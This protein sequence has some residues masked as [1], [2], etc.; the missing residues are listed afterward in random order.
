[1]LF[2]HFLSRGHLYKRLALPHLPHAKGINVVRIQEYH[3]P[4]FHRDENKRYRTLDGTCNNLERTS[5]GS[6][7]TALQRL[8]PPE[9]EDGVETPRSSGLPSPREVS[10]ASISHQN[11]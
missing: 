11:K 1:M 5:W 8:L 7:N 9:Y 6:S 3:N 2:Q 4:V 10:E